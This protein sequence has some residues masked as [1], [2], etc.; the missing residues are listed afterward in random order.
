MFLE[1]RGLLPPSLTLWALGWAHGASAEPVWVGLG[2]S[3]QLKDH[4]THSWAL[5]PCGGS[6]LAIG[7]S[8]NQGVLL[9]GVLSLL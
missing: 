7:I 9:P 1:G 8:W 5:P 6:L 4:G 3:Y 2:V